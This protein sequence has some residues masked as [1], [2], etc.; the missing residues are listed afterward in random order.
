MRRGVKR[1]RPPHPRGGDGG[2]PAP[3]APPEF[4]SSV[5]T[6]GDVDNLTLCASCHTVVRL[7]VDQVVVIEAERIA[8]GDVLHMAFCRRCRE[9]AAR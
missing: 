3:A 1:W 7:T 8:L 4:G 9:S 5:P 2:G 6:P